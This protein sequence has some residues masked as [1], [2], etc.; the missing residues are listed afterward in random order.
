MSLSHGVGVHVL[1]QTDS[2]FI[3]R[4][5]IEL[6]FFV[7]W[8]ESRWLRFILF[9]SFLFFSFEGISSC[10]SHTGCNE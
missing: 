6:V 1:R 3:I 10:R 2:E 4:V 9:F 5:Y 8:F 7:P